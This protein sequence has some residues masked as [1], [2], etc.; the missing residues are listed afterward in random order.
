MLARVQLASLAAL[1]L[2]ELIPA[3]LFGQEVKEW[4]GWDQYQVILW[5]TEAPSSAGDWLTRVSQAGFTAEQCGA[6]SDCQRF[7]PS[8]LGFYVEN[9]IPE[10]AFLHARQPVYQADWN[11]Y[12]V[13]KDRESLIRKPCFD[14]P[15]FWDSVSPKVTAFAKT[16]AGVHPLAYDL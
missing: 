15:A 3:A 8:H 10:L 9:M 12:S 14:D 7:S 5:S 16:Y 13:R 6:G 4:P 11:R 1:C 2:C